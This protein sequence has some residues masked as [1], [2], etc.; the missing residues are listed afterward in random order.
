MQVFVGK[1]APDFTAKAIMPDNSIESEFN[2][3]NYASD[4]KVVL[5]FY[6]LDFTF[7]CPSEIIAFNNRLSEFTERNTKLI[8]ISVDS[9]FSH[10][11]W[12][13]TPYNKGGVGD[14]QFPMVSDINKTATEHYNILHEEGISL[15]GTFIIDEKFI[16]RHLSVNDLPIGRN[17]DE[18][19]R[20]IDAIE[21]NTKHGEVC[22]A[23]WNKGDEGI[24]PSHKGI[25][26]YLASN[27]EKL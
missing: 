16:V 20:L 18:V 3:K 1:A 2:F 5:F 15:R 24:N 17:V 22:P 6:P 10:L 27:A 21:Y 23:G 7:V 26:H 9:H 11:A 14:I 4:H 8:A 25:A 13:N 19:L 12:K